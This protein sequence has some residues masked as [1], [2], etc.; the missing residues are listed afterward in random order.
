MQEPSFAAPHKWGKMPKLPENRRKEI[1]KFFKNKNPKDIAAI[2]D[3]AKKN[4]S[5]SPDR[6]TIES[7]LAG[8]E[9]RENSIK[10]CLNL[11]VSAGMKSANWKW[12]ES[13][14]NH[15]TIPNLVV[16]DIEL[17]NSWQEAIASDLEGLFILYRR[18]GNSPI[19][20]SEDDAGE[21]SLV[22]D[23]GP[24]NAVPDNVTPK[25]TS[26]HALVKELLYISDQ[27]S[28]NVE[29]FLVTKIGMVYKGYCYRERE[30][31]QAHFFR[32][33]ERYNIASRSMII[34]ATPESLPLG[35]FGG[36]MI[37]VKNSGRPSAFDVVLLRIPKENLSEGL[38]EKILECH[39]SG[40]FVG[41]ENVGFKKGGSVAYL[42]VETEK[43]TIMTEYEKEIYFR[44]GGTVSPP[45]NIGQTLETRI[46]KLI[47]DFFR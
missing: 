36:S 35:V 44:L 45:P 37:R 29:V 2:L 46:E 43:E 11:L 25:K 42:K 5:S 16:P 47:S 3:E 10:V 23:A 18:H 4:R 31:V 40:E 12:F 20:N 34:K 22:T 13:T 38:I 24:E 26:R 39:E 7:F 32:K 30:I 1:F 28:P 14:Q 27:N 8:S 17:N 41:Q 9:K 21:G 33:S 15:E 6:R 19:G